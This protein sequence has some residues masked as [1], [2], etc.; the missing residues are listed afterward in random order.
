[1]P[2]LAEVTAKLG[3]QVL[4]PAA[5]LDAYYTVSHGAFNWHFPVTG[6]FS[7]ASIRGPLL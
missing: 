1:M 4:S 2:Q 3:S 5:Q 7:N 6:G